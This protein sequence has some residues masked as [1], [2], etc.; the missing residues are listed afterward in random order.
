MI[1]RKNNLLSVTLGIIA[2]SFIGCNKEMKTQKTGAEKTNQVVAENANPDCVEFVALWSAGEIAQ[3]IGKPKK[4]VFMNYTVDIWENPNDEENGSPVGA[5]R[6][7]SY[8]QLLTRMGEY[9]LVESPIDGTQG[10][11]NTSHVKSIV[12]KNPKT[13]AICE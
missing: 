5:L 13:K 8:A 1:L 6:A 9:Y 12:K 10:W 11:V 4:W 2:I 7:S 3:Q